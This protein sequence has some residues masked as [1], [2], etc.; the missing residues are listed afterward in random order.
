[1]V[2]GPRR[3][4]AQDSERSRKSPCPQP[5]FRLWVKL[6]RFYAQASQTSITLE[7]SKSWELLVSLLLHRPVWDPEFL[8]GLQA[9]DGGAEGAHWLGIYE[10]I[11]ASLKVLLPTLENPLDHDPSTSLASIVNDTRPSHLE[12]TKSVAVSE[13]TVK[14]PES[15][16]TLNRYPTTENGTLSDGDTTPISS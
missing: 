2:P 5:T 10:R 1:M 16:T 3:K 14:T 8:P 15:S 12:T 4:A 6:S 13:F 7:R 11:L 9:I